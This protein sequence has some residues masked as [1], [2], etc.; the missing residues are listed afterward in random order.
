MR[1]WA[2]GRREAAFFALLA[3]GL[4]APRIAHASDMGLVVPVLFLPVEG[5]SVGGFGLMAGAYWV[6]HVATRRGLRK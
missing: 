3:L 4:G 1:T 5:I 6:A 2:R